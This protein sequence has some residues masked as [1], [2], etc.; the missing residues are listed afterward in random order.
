MAEKKVE[1]DDSGTAFPLVC[2]DVSKT[3][4][5]E[6]GMSLR[7]YA[8]I[9]LRVPNS[10]IDWLDEMIRESQRNAFAGQAIQGLLSGDA[11]PDVD[12]MHNLDDIPLRAWWAFEI[13][14]AMLAAREQKKE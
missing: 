13:A 10:G 4:V 6:T 3:Q 14:G 2:S 8:A 11:H 5:V 9:E 1:V 7:T 12:P